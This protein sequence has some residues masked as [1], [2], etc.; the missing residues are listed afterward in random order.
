MRE[1]VVHQILFQTVHEHPDAEVVSPPVRTTYATLFERATRLAN[2]L[3]RLGIGRGTVVG[4]LDI[5]SSRYLELHY[6]LSMLGAVLH[7]INFRLPAGELLETVRRAGDEW[8]L[9]WEGFR[10]A[11]AGARPLFPHWLWLTDGASE[12]EPG[13]PTL[14]GLVAEGEAALPPEADGVHED[15][16]LSILFT[17]GTTGRPKGMRYRHR[18]LLLASLQILHHLA[19]HEGGARLSSRD[20]VMPL[21]P[22]FHIHAWGTPF[23]VPYLGA[24]LVLAGRAGPAEQLELIL[25]EGVTW[26]NMVPTQLDMLLEAAAARRLERLPVKVLTGGSALPAGLASRARAL[27]VRYSLI[28]GGSDQLAT[29][30]SVVPEEADPES[31]EA[32]EALRTG[33]RP[34]PMVEVEV[35]GADGRPVPHDGQTIGEVHVRSP[36]L[37]PEGYYGE[38]E[39]SA[40]AYR[41]GWFR[42]GDLAVRLPNGLLY[43]VDREKDAIKSGGE[44]IP[45]AVL[46]AVLSRHPGVASVAVLAQP[47]P[48]WGE[49]PVAVVQPREGSPAPDEAEL[50]AFLEKAVEAGEIARFWIPDRVVAVPELPVTSAGKIHKAALRAELGLA[51]AAGAGGGPAQAAVRGPGGGPAQAAPGPEEAPGG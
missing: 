34:L 48:R 31:D 38:P 9:V 33:T 30:I 4:V 13:V 17:T 29:A 7:P 16:W 5:N 23:F 35:R 3:R 40:S 39:A 49:R 18:D 44:W 22:F 27:G 28:Y 6:A 10:D 26:L 32:A 47:D 15:D 51:P 46:E 41:D 43:V 11:M 14:E 45:S 19:L 21:I 2:G 24:K 8:L 25:Q 42:S 36:W 37:P 20:A 50:R 1:L 12:P